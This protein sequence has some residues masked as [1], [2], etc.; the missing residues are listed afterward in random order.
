MSTTQTTNDLAALSVPA[1]GAA[2]LIGVDP[3]TLS[4]WR[5]QGI[6]PAFMRVGTPHSRTLYRLDD[7]RAWLNTNRIET[8]TLG[9]GTMTSAGLSPA[10]PCSSFDSHSCSGS[11][12]RRATPFPLEYQANRREVA[13]A[14][15]VRSR[16]AARAAT[17]FPLTYQPKQALVA[18]VAVFGRSMAQRCFHVE[19]V[20]LC[21]FCTSS[22][23]PESETVLYQG[24]R[25]TRAGAIRW[26]SG[27]E[28]VTRIC[29]SVPL[30]GAEGTDAYPRAGAS[31]D[32]VSGFPR[33]PRSAGKDSP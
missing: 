1:T 20:H 22:P 27:T 19:H 13:E 11:A 31:H 5:T 33:A 10:D 29:T 30:P 8:P 3:R 2:A 15:A 26:G 25:I 16:A 28:R 23:A 32:T 17:A 21:T 6:G 9:G 18:D 24:K 12:T 14:V 4:N 7:L